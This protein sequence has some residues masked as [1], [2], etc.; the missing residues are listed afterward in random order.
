MHHVFSFLSW[1]F[2]S[3]AKQMTHIPVEHPTP[4]NHTSAVSK[5]VLD[6]CQPGPVIVFKDSF[7]FHHNSDI[8]R[9]NWSEL[10]SLPGHKG[11]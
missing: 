6:S 5:G 8:P 7:M 3:W 9:N 11:K 1:S 2:A 10:Y 4:T